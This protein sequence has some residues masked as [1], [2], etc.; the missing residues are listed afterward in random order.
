MG[1]GKAWQDTEGPTFIKCW[2]WAQRTVLHLLR[3]Q[4]QITEI[5]L[6]FTCLV[7]LFLQSINFTTLFEV[8]EN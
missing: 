8:G 1:A 4:V 7:W 6:M 3:F 2:I 5:K